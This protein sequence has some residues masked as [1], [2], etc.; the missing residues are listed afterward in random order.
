M[1]VNEREGI[2]AYVDDLLKATTAGAMKWSNV[3][4]STFVAVTSTAGAPTQIVLQR[5]ERATANRERKDVAGNV[6][7]TTDRRT[8][9]SLNVSNQL[10][11]MSISIDGD[12]DP[13]IEEK[14]SAIYEY[15]AER[16]VQEK[17]DFLRSTLPKLS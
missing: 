12:E 11:G 16:L 3:N 10:R 17:L 14:L 4:P 9:H 7:R 6:G 2:A 13:R 15:A 1:Q 5:V 8:S